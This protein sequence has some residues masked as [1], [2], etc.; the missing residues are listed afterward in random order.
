LYINEAEDHHKPARFISV[1][2][3]DVNSREATDTFF[4]MLSCMDLNAEQ[5]EDAQTLELKIVTSTIKALENK[6]QQ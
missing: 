6:I 1:H 2:P 4:D 5:L 3:E